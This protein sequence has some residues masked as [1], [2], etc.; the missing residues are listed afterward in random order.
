LDLELLN[1][2]IAATAVRPC[3][4]SR[5][6]LCGLDPS[7]EPVTDMGMPLVAEDMYHHIMTAYNTLKVTVGRHD[8]V[9]LSRSSCWPLMTRFVW[10]YCCCCCCC[11]C[12]SRSHSGSQVKSNNHLLTGARASILHSVAHNDFHSTINALSYLW[13]LLFAGQVASLIKQE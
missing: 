10:V 1:L 9:S 8:D 4:N 6:Q 5:F 11:C 13:H 12:C 7:S 3:I 2:L